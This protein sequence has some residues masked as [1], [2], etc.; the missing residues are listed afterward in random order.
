MRPRPP[1]PHFPYTT[2]FRSSFQQRRATGK[3]ADAKKVKYWLLTR[4]KWR[5]CVQ[6][7]EFTRLTKDRRCESPEFRRL[8]ERCAAQT[9]R[10]EEHTSELQS[11][12]D[13]VCRLLLDAPTP[14]IST[15]SL[16]DALPIF[17]STAPRDWQGCRC[18]KSEI[19][20]VDSRKVAEMRSSL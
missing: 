15:L 17:F 5:R 20:A 18:K 13:L 3:A 14:S 12:R 7:S 1:S 4:A 11:R 8:R 10:S 19:L 16:H 9:K 2:L 6:A